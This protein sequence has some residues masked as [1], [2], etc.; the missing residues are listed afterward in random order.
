VESILYQTALLQ[1]LLRRQVAAS[2]EAAAL[3]DGPEIATLTL[4]PTDPKTTLVLALT[5]PITK[6]TVDV[7]AFRLYAFDPAA[8][9]A[10]TSIDVETTYDDSVS[11]PR[12]VVKLSNDTLADTVRYRLVSVVPAD[13]PIVDDTMKP[14]RPL[15]F[16]YHFQ[17]KTDAG[18]LVLAPIA[19]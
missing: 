6:T 10:W 7:D 18:S 12:L 4:D 9:P 17:I 16:S 13:Q 5:G 11:P 19:P 14:L 3:L 15:R 8:T 1:D 2:M